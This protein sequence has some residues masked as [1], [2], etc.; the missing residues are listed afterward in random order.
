MARRLTPEA[1]RAEIIA[2]AQAAIASEGYQALSLREIA[3]RCGMSAPGVMHYF[4]DMPSLLEAVLDH[5]DETE[6]AAFL[7]RNDPSASLLGLL[8]AARKYYAAH[9]EATRSFDLL[10]A[11]ALDPRHPA[12]DYYV[13]HNERT[14]ERLRPQIER[15]YEDAEHVI[16]VLAILLDGTRVRRLREPETNWAETDEDWRAIT[17]LLDSFPRRAA[18]SVD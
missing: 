2:V 16:Q 18:A 12:H 10:E 5:R 3:R 6:L 14:L 13:K 15:E 7:P 9:A 8:E 11:E 1:R 4:P 17:K